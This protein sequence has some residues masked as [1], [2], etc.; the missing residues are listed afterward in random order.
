M[1]DAVNKL[2]K[3]MDAPHSNMGKIS[4]WN[5]GTIDRIIDIVT[6][7]GEQWRRDGVDY[8]Q[9]TRENKY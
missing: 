9:R 4:D 6:D 5:D 8:R 7:N 2:Y 3:L 1:D